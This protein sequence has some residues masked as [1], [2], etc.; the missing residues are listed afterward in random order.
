MQLPCKRTTMGFGKYYISESD[1]CQIVGPLPDRPS[2]LHRAAWFC[3]FSPCTFQNASLNRSPE[4]PPQ[5][6]LRPPR[7]RI[8]HRR[9]S[10]LNAAPASMFSTP[11]LITVPH[12]TLEPMLPPTPAGNRTPERTHE[13]PPSGH[14]WPATGADAVQHAGKDPIQPNLWVVGCF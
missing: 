6:D 5:I 12:P 9:P 1:R 3:I 11:L 4:T 14:Q 2:H 7:D 13:G 10:A 8:S